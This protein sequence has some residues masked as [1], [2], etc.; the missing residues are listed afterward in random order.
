MDW[1]YLVIAGLCEIGWPLVK[2]IPGS[3]NRLRH[4]LAVAAM[5]RAASPVAR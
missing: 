5:A 1:L 4:R 2:N 3:A